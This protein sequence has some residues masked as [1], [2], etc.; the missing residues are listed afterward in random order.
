MVRIDG[1]LTVETVPQLYPEGR[2]LIEQSPGGLQMDL[3][4]V[5]RADSGGLALLVDWLATATQQGRSL[6]YVNLP[7]TVLALAGLSEVSSLLSER[8]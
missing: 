6:R 2:R 3:A 7:Q 8:A 1:D 5:A 4:G